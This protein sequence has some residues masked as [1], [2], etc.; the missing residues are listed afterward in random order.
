MQPNIVNA[1]VRDINQSVGQ[2]FAYQIGRHFR[3]GTDLIALLS[4][5]SCW[6]DRLQK[7][8]YRAG[9]R[10]SK[11]DRGEIWQESRPIVL[12][13]NTSYASTDGVGFGAHDN[14]HFAQQSAATWCVK[15]KRLPAPACFVRQLLT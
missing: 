10:R 2:T 1:T 15:T 14:H 8:P 9:L 11:S 3:S 12:Q 6:G 13:V 4:S 7:S 5:C